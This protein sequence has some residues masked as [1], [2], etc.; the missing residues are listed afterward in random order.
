MQIAETYDVELNVGD[1]NLFDIPGMSIGSIDV[2]EDIYSGI[3]S[4]TMSVS[5]PQSLFNNQ[6]FVD[7]SLFKLSI[8]GADIND[9]YLFRVWDVP[10]IVQKNDSITVDLN[11]V[12]DVYEI[13][14][15]GNKY[16]ACS[17]TSG[18]F[19]KIA[20]ENNWE[21]DID[22]TNDKQTWVAGRRNLFQFM[23]HLCKYGYSDETSCM[24]WFFDRKKRLIYKNLSKLFKEKSNNIWQFD[25]GFGDYSNKIFGYGEISVKLTAGSDNIVNG[26]YG[27]DFDVF[28]LKTYKDKLIHPNKVIAESATINISKELSQGLSYDWFPFDVGNFHEH[29]YL[30]WAQNRRILSTYS[31][32]SYLQCQC[33]QKFRLGQIVNLNFRDIAGEENKSKSFTSLGIISS[34]HTKITPDMVG[35]T[36]T[37]MSQG[38]NSKNETVETY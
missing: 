15:D 37:I 12:L 24:I 1:L 22:E 3:P 27:N 8:N 38:V 30:A 6:C 34:I 11:G 9:T 10:K 32:Y 4:F 21:N 33:L 17:T 16:N 25:K 14:R 2:Y 26:G 5:V 29:Y 23:H 28:E 36:V 13:Y 7:G 31:T 18:L 35:A 20:S 19:K